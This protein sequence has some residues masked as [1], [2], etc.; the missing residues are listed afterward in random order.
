VQANQGLPAMRGGGGGP[1]QRAAQRPP[2]SRLRSDAGRPTAP[3]AC[4]PA[5]LPAYSAL[6]LFLSGIISTA[7][8]AVASADA[9]GAVLGEVQGVL[10]A[11]V[12]AT[13]EGC[14]LGGWVRGAPRGTAGSRQHWQARCCLLAGS[15]TCCRVPAISS[16]GVFPGC[17][18][19]SS[20][21]YAIMSLPAEIAANLQCLAPWLDSLPDPVPLR[22]DVVAAR[23]SVDAVLTPRLADLSAQLGGL[24]AVMAPAPAPGAYTVAVQAMVDSR[25]LLL[26]A[27]DGLIPQAQVGCSTRLLV[28]SL[29]TSRQPVV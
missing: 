18:P 20:W 14:W 24:A 21:H 17:A 13:G 6:Q 22:A 5:C 8:S 26:D 9:V 25:P 23:A 1:T 16:V 28:A 4:L 12:N 2:P 3:A 15:A 19:D 27:P 11:E 29:L 10:D 7:E